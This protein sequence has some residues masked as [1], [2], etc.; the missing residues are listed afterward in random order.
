MRNSPS[1]RCCGLECL[2]VNMD[3]EGVDVI[4]NVDS[5]SWTF[6]TGEYVTTSADALRHTTATS[7]VH[8]WKVSVIVNFYLVSEDGNDFKARVIGGFLDDENYLFAEFRMVWDGLESKW[9][10]QFAIGKVEGGVETVFQEHPA[11]VEATVTASNTQR[12]IT[13]CWDGDQ[14]TGTCPDIGDPDAFGE[15]G[16]DILSENG[17]T[18]PGNMAGIGTGDMT[19]TQ[20]GF[21]SFEFT[22]SDVE[23]CG[24]CEESC[25][26]G[27]S[28]DDLL[29]EISG[30]GSSYHTWTGGGAGTA[31]DIRLQA[32]ELNGT[33]TLP[34]SN[35]IS[36]DIA[37]EPDSDTPHGG[38]GH[39]RWGL[40]VVIDAE[41]SNG[42]SWL[43]CKLS[44]VIN[45]S[46][47]VGNVL[48]NMS[49]IRSTTGTDCY[50][51]TVFFGNS[52]LTA[53]AVMRFEAADP[54]PCEEWTDWQSTTH[55]VLFNDLSF[56]TDFTVTYMEG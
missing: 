15:D 38:D 36:A 2:I 51:A 21:E 44:M 47:T 49:F 39:C 37:G 22:L 41:Y 10:Q 25:C 27:P 52:L 4:P 7:G 3:V 32:S 17:I 50:T 23:D 16:L 20:V 26:E 35:Q 30:G 18:P 6:P 53:P 33:Y 45:V 13:L 9:V 56:A 5:G 48:I 42:T 14:L 43:P 29:L 8:P 12:T 31:G 34:Y 55:T 54:I 1:C 24:E 46:K 40:V 28:P 11:I 19:G